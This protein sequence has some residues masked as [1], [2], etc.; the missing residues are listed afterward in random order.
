MSENLCQIVRDAEENYLHGAVDMGKYVQ[1]DMHETI[2]TIDAYLNSKHISGEKD[3]LGRDKPFFNIVTAATNIWYRATDIDRKDIR[4]L[5]D[6]SENTTLAF[7][8]TCILQNWMKESRFG[9]FLNEWGRTLAR[10]G[11]AVVKFVEQ[12]GKLVA[13][14]IPW[15]RMIAD[16]ISFDAIPRIEKFYLTPAQLK[17][18][19]NYNPKTVKELIDALTTRKT[20]DNHQQDNQSKYIELY[21]VHGDMS[22][23]VY[24]ESRGEEVLEGDEDTTFQQMHVVSFVKADNGEYD[25]YTLFSGKEKKD[26][27]MITHLIKED[28]RTLSIGAVEHLFQAQWM[29]NHAMKNQKDTLDVASKLIFQTADKTF[30]GRNILS[31]IETGDILLHADNMPL[32]QANNS[33]ADV[34]A[35]QSFARDWMNL[36][37]EI[38]STPESARGITPPSGVALG[39]VQIVTSQGLSLFEIM[40]ENKGLHIEEMMREF[41]L[42]FIMK[43]MDTKDEVLAI[44]DQ[45]MIDKIDAKYISHMVNKEVNE[46]MVDR[47]IES[48]ETGTELPT[49]EEQMEMEASLTSNMQGQLDSLMAGQ[50]F[51]KPDDMDEMTWKEA[52]DGFEMKVNVEVTNEN[53]DK[54]AVLQ[55][56]NMLLTS[57]ASNPAILNDPNARMI[58]TEILKETGRISPL[59]LTDVAPTTAPTGGTEALPVA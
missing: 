14:V 52:M 35:L 25:D 42:P 13:T 5:P 46:K 30:K 51:F 9:V 16:P 21:E 41:I 3:S 57:I 55:T 34:S 58:F 48:F 53:T 54:Q 11:S 20:L 2:E 26:P 28:G 29:T 8:A 24:K 50:R 43:Q 1:W 12:D 22:L 37:Q 10:Y 17:K 36:G 45:N 56:L 47:T 27:Y 18:N 44:L 39:T 19:K 15:N 31:A 38:T 32:T 23:A 6:T 59:Q 4:I 49:P 40:T 33:K 7:I